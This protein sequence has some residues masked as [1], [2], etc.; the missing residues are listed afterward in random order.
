MELLSV[1]SIIFAFT[2]PVLTGFSQEEQFKPGPA[3]PSSSK[4]A[5]SIPL[6]AFINKSIIVTDKSLVV[7]V[8]KNGVFVLHER[9]N[10]QLLRMPP[11]ADDVIFGDDA[12]SDF[13]IW[14]RQNPDGELSAFWRAYPHYQSQAITYAQT[15][16]FDGNS[17]LGSPASDSSGALPSSKLPRST[18]DLPSVALSKPSEAKPTTLTPS[19][20]PA[21]SAPWNVIVVLIVAATGLLWLLVKNRK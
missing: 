1:K 8:R 15:V 7:L 5:T 4:S 17:R 12:A 9:E 21:S 10:Q 3:F 19:D 13:L 18:P 16:D 11:E 2:F 14:H 6:S 20:E